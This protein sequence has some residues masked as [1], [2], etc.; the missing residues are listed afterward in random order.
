MCTH[1]PHS[2]NS[3]TYVG[4]SRLSPG[5]PWF[6]SSHLGHCVSWHVRTR[7]Q[8]VHENAGRT[9]RDEVLLPPLIPQGHPADLLC[10]AGCH[11]RLF[12]ALVKSGVF[13]SS[14]KQGSHISHHHPLRF[15]WERFNCVFFLYNDVLAHDWRITFD[16]IRKADCVSM[17]PVKT[18]R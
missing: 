7:W 4:A 15:H 6:K 2:F 12:S 10:A 14:N 8:Q 9:V 3:V 11:H 18:V 16:V 13:S 5:S 1:S 17:F